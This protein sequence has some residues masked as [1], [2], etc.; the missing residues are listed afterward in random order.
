MAPACRDQRP[1]YKHP[2]TGFES[3][4]DDNGHEGHVERAEHGWQ[5]MPSPHK[6]ISANGLNITGDDSSIRLSA[7]NS[8]KTKVY[9]G[10]IKAP[11]RPQAN[12]VQGEED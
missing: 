5:P 1:D 2:A 8:V 9:P 4:P 10:S 3:P 7:R 6:L 12:Q 11:K